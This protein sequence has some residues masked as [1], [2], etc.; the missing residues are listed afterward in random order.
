M[1]TTAQSA[2]QV[3]DAVDLSSLPSH[4]TLTAAAGTGTAPQTNDTASGTVVGNSLV[5]FTAY[6]SA[7]H[8]DDL[9]NAL[10][11][12][13]LMAVQQ[14]H[15]A[16]NNPV[17]YYQYVATFLSNIGFTGQAINFGSYTA[18]TAT[19]EIDQVVLEI[20]GK[21]LAPA[22][23][24]IVEAALE[25]LK[26][27]ASDNGAP[28]A[29]Y[30]S[31]STSNSARSFSVGLANETNGSVAFQVGAFSFTGTE[32]TTKFLWMTYSASSVDIQNGS[33]TFSLNDD[34]YA[35]VR[36][37]VKA[38]LASHAAGYIANLPD[39]T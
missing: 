31:N 28:W 15:N 8:K 4:G 21:I 9:N 17:D 33:T 14:G 3:V 30:S 18:S 2:A 24:G 36:A 22:D 32:T 23:L 13:Q 6:V 25:A 26:G 29:I 1:S 12:A 16:V 10:G 20:L 37:T 38:K 11:L 39:L 35:G 7:Q 27:S 5:S 19:V 34:I